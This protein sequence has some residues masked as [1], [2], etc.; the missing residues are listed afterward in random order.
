MR[1]VNPKNEDQFSVP[2]DVANW[3]SVYEKICQ[4]KAANNEN[5]KHEQNLLEI[6]KSFEQ[7]CKDYINLFCGPTV[8][9]EDAL[10]PQKWLT[11]KIDNVLLDYW[12]PIQKA[13]EQYRVDHYRNILNRG[14]EKLGSFQQALEQIMPDMPIVLY[15]ENTGK[16]KRYP[17]SDIYLIGV[18]IPDGY[19]DD[20]NA[21]W[22]ELGHHL[23]WNSRI[24]F[25][26]KNFYQ[27][28]SEG[29]FE[30]EIADAV[31]KLETDGFEKNQIQKILNAWT[32]EIFAD[33]I[34]TMIAGQGFVSAATDKVLKSIEKKEN[35][36]QS[37]GRHLFPYFLPFARECAKENQLLP[38]NQ[39]WE[40]HYGEI[41][42]T[43]L[44]GRSSKIR[45]IK[46]ENIRIALE[47]SIKNIK[48]KLKQVSFG[49]RLTSRS[50]LEE[51]VN[52]VRKA[53][54]N[55]SPEEFA[56][57]LLS[58]NIIEGGAD[59]NCKECGHSNSN[60]DNKCQKCGAK[61][62]WWTYILI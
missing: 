30:R 45:I 10:F 5:S 9:A 61:R 50:A 13:A 51:L 28:R 1:P 21:M 11:G 44:R 48:S 58:T 49:S 60:D 39:T 3:K 19:E 2:K 20:W 7:F 24:N 23:Y 32:E 36:F 25:E 53:Y 62:P 57:K 26:K 34:G 56:R 43:G 47:N 12:E 22:H 41:T 14:Y 27:G 59:W 16:Y 46:I 40:K 8:K 33:I 55:L 31:K 52:F 15:L 37:D 18:P 4:D 42:F 17:F 35:L 6:I 29:F 38:I 54:P